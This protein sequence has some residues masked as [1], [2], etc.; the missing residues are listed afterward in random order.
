MDARHNDADFDGTV[1]ETSDR[2]G[3][4]AGTNHASR[5]EEWDAR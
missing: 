3:H 1:L 4:V 5:G 2:V